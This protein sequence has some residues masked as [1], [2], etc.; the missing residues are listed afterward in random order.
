MI[1]VF[2]PEI[3]EDDIAEVVA[4][5]RRGEISG[6]FGEAIPAFEREFAAYVGCDHGV[7]VTSGTTA[8]QL[9]VA[10]LD[11]PAG[12]EIL[13]SASTNIATALACYHNGCVAVAVDS[14]DQTWNL[15]LDLLEGLISEKTRAIIPVHLFGHPVAMDRLMEFAGRHKL[16]VI[17]DCAESHGATWKGRVTGGFGQMSAF[18]FYAN[19]IITTGEGGMVTTNDAALAE[20]LR[21]LRNLAFGKPRFLHRSR[22]PVSHDRHAGCPGPGAVP[23]DRPLHRRKAAHGT[24]LQ[25]Y[26]GGHSGPAYA[27]RAAG[28]AQCLLDVRRDGR[29]RVRRLTRPVEQIPRRQRRRNADLLLPDEHAAVLAPAAGISRCPLS[30]SR[31]PLGDRPDILPSACSLTEPTIAHICD[32]IR[33][34]RIPH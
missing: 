23:Q 9:A 14:E 22:P 13:V 31:A 7:A 33:R 8:L 19:K 20:K 10:V 29:S 28:G 21:S 26:V 34:A 25:L 3:G 6:S 1:P 32:L 16:T 24:C 12:S 2:E 5:L 30:G 15:D 4:A 18:S 11:L 17:E 27:A